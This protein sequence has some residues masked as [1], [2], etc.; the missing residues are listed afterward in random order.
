MILN[1]LPAPYSSFRETVK[2]SRETL[3]LEEVLLTLWPKQILAQ[4]LSE[5]A[6]GLSVQRKFNKPGSWKKRSNKE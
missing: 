2:Y 6:E 4:P 1:S 3:S 5:F